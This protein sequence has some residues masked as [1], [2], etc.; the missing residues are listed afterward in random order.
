MMAAL[1]AS[2]SVVLSGCASEGGSTGTSD[3]KRDMFE[4]TVHLSFGDRLFRAAYPGEP[5]FFPFDEGHIVALAVT[6]PVPSEWAFSRS[7]VQV[8]LQ[9]Q[10][11]AGPYLI[12]PS[13]TLAL[14]RRVPLPAYLCAVVE[15]LPQQLV[16]PSAI[17]P[18]AITSCKP[19]PPE[20][21]TEGIEA[22]KYLPDEPVLREPV[23]LEFSTLAPAG[24]VGAM[25]LAFGSSWF[26]EIDLDAKPDSTLP[27]F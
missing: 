24:T 23:A 3:L 2:S 1:A 11:S 9:G 21:E 20:F 4:M 8:G 15:G 10:G 5:H 6:S 13:I 14:M 7:P 27:D 22:R 19:I 18:A 26:T 25:G 16:V 12:H 17:R